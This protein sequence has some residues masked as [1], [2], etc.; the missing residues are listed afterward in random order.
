MSDREIYNPPKAI[1]DKAYFQTMD[2]YTEMYNRSIEDPEK[3]W[4]EEAD[5]FVWFEKWDQVRKYNY[6]V[7]NG[8]ISIEWFKGGKTNI[9]ANCLDRYHNT[10][11]D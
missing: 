5:K 7:K 11:A 2:Q 1:S 10:R 6:N 4:A 9:T 3:F 8:P